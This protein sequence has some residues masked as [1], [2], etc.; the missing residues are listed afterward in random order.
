MSVRLQ[1]KPFWNFTRNQ[2][3]QLVSVQSCWIH[4]M[5]VVQHLDHD[6]AIQMMRDLI[7]LIQKYDNVCPQCNQVVHMQVIE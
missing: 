7:D 1:S 3:P 6:R 2:P 4:A 5:Q